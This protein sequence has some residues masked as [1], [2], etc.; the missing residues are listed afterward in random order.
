M[1][2]SKNL[3]N[4]HPTVDVDGHIL[5]P[6]NTWKDYLEPKFRTRAIELVMEKSGEV[7]LIDGKPLEVVRNRTALLGGIDGDPK[8]LLRGGQKLVY[9]DGCPAGSYLP[10]ERLK[11]MDKE[12]VSYT[13][14]T[15]PTTPY[16]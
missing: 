11:V 15:L 3:Y 10:D 13:H 8:T 1:S 16:V 4:K 9:E 12:A 7:L 2:C 14:L 5:E 6:R